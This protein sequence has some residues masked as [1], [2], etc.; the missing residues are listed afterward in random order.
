MIMIWCRADNLVF[1]GL[2]S[3]LIVDGY[4]RAQQGGIDNSGAGT[5]LLR[6]ARAFGL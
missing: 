3:K 4:N 5:K 1:M 6:H 2:G